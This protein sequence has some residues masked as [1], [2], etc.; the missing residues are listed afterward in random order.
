MSDLVTNP[1]DPFSRIA[2]HIIH[3]QLLLVYWPTNN[4]GHIETGSELTD[5][6]HE[7][8]HTNSMVT[9]D[10]S[11]RSTTVS[12]FICSINVVL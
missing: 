11:L 2:A 1:E 4:K 3:V 7:A 8:G 5:H 12:H 6:M 10:N 9:R